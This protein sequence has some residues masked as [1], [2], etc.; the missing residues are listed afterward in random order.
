M[1]TVTTSKD[2]ANSLIDV[3]EHFCSFKQSAWMDNATYLHMFQSH[4]EAIDHLDLDLAF[5]YCILERESRMLVKTQQCGCLDT[6][7]GG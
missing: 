7:Q 4:M 6:S 5:T 1:Y 3:M 2:M